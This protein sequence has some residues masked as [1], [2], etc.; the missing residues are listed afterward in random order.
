LFPVRETVFLTITVVVFTF[1]EALAFVTL[2]W[3]ENDVSGLTPFQKFVA[4]IFQSISTRTAGFNIID[5]SSIHP[6]LQVFYVTMMYVSAYPIALSVRSSS[7]V[8]EE[9]KTF[10]DSRA[11]KE[12]RTGVLFQAKHL[13]VRDAA[14]VIAALFI[15][16]I[17]E[18]NKLQTEPDFTIWRILFEC[19]SAYGTVGISLGW[20]GS[21][22][23]FSGQ[24]GTV[25]K[26]AMCGLM[27]MG[28]HRGLPESV[29]RALQL[30]EEQDLQLTGTGAKSH[31]PR[32]PGGTVD[33]EPRTSEDLGD[34]ANSKLSQVI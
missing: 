21:S 7:M 14:Y 10:S 20:A 29:D 1:A 17:A 24:F 8:K 11:S 25:S 6:A 18:K 13:V 22:V 5:L 3:N 15:I 30:D 9:V 2:N 32:L 34:L 33:T 27:L 23:S 31:L 28:R 4:A 26:V 12:Y 19:V 16:C